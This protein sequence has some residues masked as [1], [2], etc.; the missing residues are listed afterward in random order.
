M[1]KYSFILALIFS[2]GIPSQAQEFPQDS[3][4]IVS[5]GIK[6]G[7]MLMYPKDH[8]AATKIP[9]V[10]IIQGSGPTD[11]D[12]NSNL[13]TGKN[14]ALL[15]IAQALAE[16]GI[17]SLRYD[18]RGMGMSGQI[19]VIETNLTFDDFITDAQ[20]WVSYLSKNAKF[21]KIGVLGHSQGALIASV[22]SQSEKVSAL[23]SAAGAGNSI[24]QIIL[25]QIKDNPFNPAQIYNEAE[26]IFKQLE[27]GASV[28]SIPPY[29]S[30]LFRKDIQ[31]FM[32]S[33]MKYDPKE[34]LKKVNCAIWI[35]NGT[36]D[37]QVS[38]E[39]AGALKEAQP[40]A[41][42]TIIEGMNHVLKESPEERNTNLATYS[43]PNL[44]LHPEFVNKI[45]S[46]FNK[47]LR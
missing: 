30:S 4:S 3:V 2:F 42:L 5:D 26:E 29:F 38:I 18:K 21:G 41:E 1:T 28:D 16:E 37:I 12:G 6:L 32:S 10:L 27:I 46:F 43:N 47:Q 33:W 45:K 17:A 39:D 35:V 34:E 23:V 9:V 20:N 11:K 8:P 22:V 13:S 24:D 14:N 40:R 7:G 31:P 36:T 44:P 25:K 15:Y 19:P